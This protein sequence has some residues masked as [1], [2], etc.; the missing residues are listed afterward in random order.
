MA[1]E[2][3]NPLTKISEVGSLESEAFE[4]KANATVFS[5]TLSAHELYLLNQSGLEPV[6]VVVG[7]IVYSVGVRGIVNT[8]KRALVRG[9]MT[10]FTHLNQLARE[11]AIKRL[12]DE[13]QSVGGTGVVGVHL[14]NIQY[15]DF[16]EVT[17]TGTA[18]RKSAA[19][20]AGKV[21]IV[22][23]A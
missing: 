4:G 9:E 8:V 22:V 19:G 23:G 11:L 5:T 13:A 20:A 14:E 17:A 21:E 1:R 2:Q 12:H 10:D 6:R 3:L 7:N 15:G 16:I 18:V